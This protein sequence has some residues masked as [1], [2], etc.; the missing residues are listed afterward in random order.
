MALA[1]ARIGVRVESELTKQVIFWIKFWIKTDVEFAKFVTTVGL[2]SIGKLIV[3][4]LIERRTDNQ[5]ASSQAFL[6]WAI[7]EGQPNRPSEKGKSRPPVQGS[8]IS[9]GAGN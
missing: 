7:P 5:D 6:S 4:W 8:H 9:L 2:E 3:A 1:V